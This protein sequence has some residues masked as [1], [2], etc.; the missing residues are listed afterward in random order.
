MNKEKFM[1]NI[2]YIAIVTIILG[3]QRFLLLP[4]LTKNLGPE[5]YGVWANT[6]NTVLLLTAI[7]TLGM[8]PT[9]TRF[10]SSEKNKQKISKDF[11]MIFTLLFLSSLLF[12]IICFF[13]SD[14]I[15]FFILKN[16]D[17]SIF[18]KIACSLIILETLN[19]I[20]VVFYKTLRMFKTYAYLYIVYAGIEL[21]SFWYLLSNSFGL[22]WIF[23]ISIIIKA[24]LMFIGLSVVKTKVGWH[25]PSLDR[26]KPYISYGFPLILLPFYH[27][28]I[29]VSDQYVIGFFYGAKEIGV[30]SLHYSLAFILLNFTSIIMFVLY[31]TITRLWDEHKIK[32][33]KEFTKFSYKYIMM[34]FIPSIIGFFVLYEGIIRNISTKEFL[35]TSLLLIILAIATIF[36]SIASLLQTILLLLKKTRFI[37]RITLISAITNIILN[38][39]FVYYFGII[40]AAISTLITFLMFTILSLV[41]TH[42]EYKFDFMPASIIKFMVAAIIMGIILF[43]F[44]TSINIFYLISQIL[45]G[46]AVYFIILILLR[47]ISRQEIRFFLSIYKK[48]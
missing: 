12:S 25:S 14:T 4:L 5:Y 38:I 34:L 45:V 17:Y 36:N 9:I 28:I 1:K 40:G 33:V 39:I 44:S 22:T 21:F 30:Y 19:A 27:W 20:L 43:F 32:E 13:L 18:I 6:I 48:R 26:I 42:K 16:L 2:V 37:N 41:Y 15:A 29:R 8:G 24:L 3:L 10:L 46:A 47:A 23:I 7:A 31:P 11:F 35:S